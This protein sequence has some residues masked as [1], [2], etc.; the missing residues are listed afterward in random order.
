MRLASAPDVPSCVIRNWTRTKQILMVLYM[1]QPASWPVQRFRA[2][3]D[4]I[5]TETGLTQ[6][7]L[8]ELVPMDQSQLSRWKSGSSRPKFDS[9][10][11][12]GEALRARYPAV[13][14][15]P[16]QLLE[17]AG[18]S[19]PEPVGHIGQVK[20][21][22]PPPTEGVRIEQ[23]NDRHLQVD[24]TLDTEVT[25]AEVF[26][27]LGDLS[28]NE[29]AMI[30]NMRLLGNAPAEIGGA[31]LMLRQFNQRRAAATPKAPGSREEAPGSR[32]E[33]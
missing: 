27:R 4:R 9:L 13:G 17:S 20:L 32:E 15:G 21:T 25:M 18:Y 23:V 14:I 5:L 2:T 29:Q 11:I 24:M 8:A 30:A 12:L 1:A 33:A 22:V 3:L 26:E 6:A 31:V 19:S 16:N 7:G 10:K 28:L